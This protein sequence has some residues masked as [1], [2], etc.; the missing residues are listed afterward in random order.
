[1][2][3]VLVA[4]GVGTVLMSGLTQQ[5][6]NSA[7]QS[8]AIGKKVFIDSTMNYMQS[9]LKDFC[10]KTFQRG[11]SALEAPASSYKFVLDANNHGIEAKKI[12]L[13][14]PTPYVL[15]DKF[16]ADDI[17][18]KKIELVLPK[19]S[20]AKTTTE[21]EKQDASLNLIFT[22][23]GRDLKRT[24][25]LLDYKYTYAM[26]GSAKNQGN[27]R[28]GFE[29]KGC[30]SQVASG[31]NPSVDCLTLDNE[32][33]VIGCGAGKDTTGQG[34]TFVGYQAGKSNTPGPLNTFL[35]YQAGKSTTGG[36]NTFIGAH[37]GSEGTS[38]ESNVFI[39]ANTGPNTSA[40]GNTFV[41]EGAGN[42][43][44]TGQDNVSIGKVS[45]DLNET[46]NNNISLGA[47]S[48]DANVS[49]DDNIFIGYLSGS[50]LSVINPAADSYGEGSRNI[51]IGKETCGSA[52]DDTIL[53]GNGIKATDD[54]K[55]NIGNVYTSEIKS[56][57]HFG[58][59]AYLKE[60]RLCSYKYVPSLTSSSRVQNKECITLTKNDVINLRELMRLLR[61]RQQ[62]ERLNTVIRG[63]PT[64]YHSH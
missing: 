50:N 44:T 6:I 8:K 2:V 39:G 33:S 19:T 48:A 55:I 42:K 54:G 62:R 7:K 10:T 24:I 25:P 29:I 64:S 13:D 35:G 45:G 12:K 22:E 38:G 14:R 15:K 26:S 46:G 3:G 16:K 1:M 36:F 37:A 17:H 41:G 4:M 49:G 47:F 61:T 53:I 40:H 20:I 5:Q 57:R 21:T 30:A 11:S 34:N 32:K 28:S 9:H 51:C 31:G 59:E 60:V 63:I 27:Y 56:S 43:N 52:R 23:G 18:L 58:R